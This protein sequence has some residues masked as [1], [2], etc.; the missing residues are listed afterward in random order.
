MI[1]HMKIINKSLVEL[2]YHLFPDSTRAIYTR[3]RGK[4]NAKMWRLWHVWRFW[5]LF[6]IKLMINFVLQ[7]VLFSWN[8]TFTEITWCEGNVNTVQFPAVV[9]NS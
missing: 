4:H 9:R 5:L 7:I 3:A 1:A 2:N 8:Q 6:R